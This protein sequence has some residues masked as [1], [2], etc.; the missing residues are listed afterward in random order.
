MKKLLLFLL[1]TL[2]ALSLVA[3]GGTEPDPTPTPDDSTPTTPEDPAPT[4]PADPE[5]DPSLLNFEGVTFS[6]LT[7]TYDGEEHIIEVAGTLPEGTVVTYTNN[8]GTDADTYHASAKLECEGYNQLTLTAT[9][10]IEKADIIGITFNNGSVEYDTQIH[11]IYV[12]GNVPAGVTVNYTYNGKSASGVSEVGEYDVVATLTD[13]NHNTL[14]LSAKLTIKSTESEL[15]MVNFGGV[16]YFQ[17]DLDGKKLYKHDK[18]VVTKVNNDIAECF[19]TD[20]TDLY[21]YST[22]LFSKTIKKISASGT[23]STVYSVSGDY[24][25]TDGTYLY[26]SVN[27]LLLGTDTNGIYKYNLNGQDAEPVRISTDQAAY[28]TVYG[29]YIYYSNLSNNKYLCKVSVNG[30]N[31]T[32]I[33]NEK[34]EYIIEDNGVLYFD[35]SKT[36]GSAIYKYHIS[37][38]TLTKMTTDSGKYLTKL[39]NDIY[40]I[41]ND[42]LTS[43]L[44]G[45]GIYKISVLSSGSAS[46]TKVIAATDNGYSSLTSDGKYLYYYKLNDKHLWRYDVITGEETDLME[47]FVPPV[48]EIVPVGNT[49]IA[50]YKGEIY[51]TNPLDGLSNGA[52]LYKYNPI[53]NQHIKVLADDVAGIWFNDGMMYYS[54]CILTNYALFRMDL[55]TGE[56]IKINSDRCEDLIFEGEYLYY[57][58]VELVGNN[59]IRRILIADIGKD[60]IEPEVIYSDKN[61]AVT[62]MYK[63]GDTFYFVM[64]PA[65]GY[66]KLYSYTIGEKKGVDLGE[67]AFEVVTDGDTLYFYDD[68]ANAIK[69]YESGNT[70]T[71]VTKVTV[72]DLA[73]SGGVLYFSS[74]EGTK[75]VY[76]YNLNTEKLVKISASVGE[77]LTVIDGK[78]W[79]V[80]T[81]VGYVTDYPV[82]SGD[83]DC[84]LYCYDGSTLTKK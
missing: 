41:N 53:T 58:N 3:C 39:G 29:G 51:Y 34:V 22:S 1:I 81:A 57:L 68:G 62:G 52:C 2:L 35:S 79:F 19:F 46:G 43:N 28:L 59:S 76:S 25:T 42:L 80:A 71:L 82:H 54:T 74:T 61:I 72:N 49:V 27:N 16:I 33:H 24:L 45:D 21:Y 70:T 60:D 12:V 69:C 47:G 13:P 75:G 15:N 31:S 55:S 66:Q 5:P 83:G 26:Y 63:V 10:K 64:N 11:S 7:V 38:A 23:V 48:V 6:D 84:A 56:S 18:G 37:Q 50:E 65:I 40:Y 4:P 20:G 77:G 36:L 8:K 30:G 67:K 9:L 17:N 44:F 73:I 32:V 14:T 78:L